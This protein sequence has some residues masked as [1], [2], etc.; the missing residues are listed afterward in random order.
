M[1]S[2]AKDEEAE[3]IDLSIV[4]AATTDDESSK[5]AAKKTCCTLTMEIIKIS[6]IACT[7]LFLLIWS[8]IGF[9]IYDLQAVSIDEPA[10]LLIFATLCLCGATSLDVVLR[11]K[12]GGVA[13]IVFGSLGIFAAVCWLISGILSHN[14]IVNDVNGNVDPSLWMLGSAIN[15]SVL[16]YECIKLCKS[17]DKT[18]GCK[19][20]LTFIGLIFVIVANVLFLGASAWF[21]YIVNKDW[22]DLGG[23]GGGFSDYDDDIWNFNYEDDFSNDDF[24]NDDFFNYRSLSLL[25]AYKNGRSAMGLYIGGSLMYIVHSVLEIVAM[26]M[27]CC[28]G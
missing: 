17:K 2:S 10:G 14:S 26:S 24:Y 8:I 27:S 23:G 11:S 22:F 12:E 18:S 5:P 19:Y 20:I 25:D 13:N 3:V 4:P 9:Q 16:V 28:C 1:F 21:I 6:L 15:I 7:S